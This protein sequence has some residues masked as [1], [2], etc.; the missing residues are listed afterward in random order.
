MTT[1]LAQANTGSDNLTTTRSV[2]KPA[3]VDAGA[4]GVFWLVR[5]HEADSFPAVTPP[6]GAVHRGT[7]TTVRMETR[8]YLHP[9]TD[10]T[11]FAYSWTGGRWST[12]AALWFSGVDPDADL[13]TVPFQ[14]AVGSGTLIDTLTVTSTTDSALAWHINTIDTGG[15]SHTPPAGFTE[16]ADVSPWAAAYRITDLDGSQNASDATVSP[17]TP[18][19]AGLV[20]LPPASIGGV[21]GDGE[22]TG[23]AALSAAGQRASTSGAE[24]AATADLAGAGVRQASADAAVTATAALAADGTASRPGQAALAATVDLTAG[25]LRSSLAGVALA[26]DTTLTAHGT[27]GRHSPATLTATIALTA[28]GTTSTTGSDD[29][30]VTVEAPTSPWSARPPQPSAWAAQAPHPS[31][32]EVGWPC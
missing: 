28:T 18:W 7:I 19:A 5:W 15:V 17:S 27:A 14:S 16:V 3:G 32:W 20:A 25:G 13:A 10:E 1:Y 24:M 31:S 4:V 9:V 6:A 30:D 22:L 21:T 12:L 11:S 29:V 26:A 23:T 2:T 8:C